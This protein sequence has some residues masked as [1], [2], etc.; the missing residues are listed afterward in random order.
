MST[1]LEAV[2]AALVAGKELPFPS[3]L[4]RGVHKH[5]AFSKD[6]TGYI[7][8][9]PWE[10][11]AKTSGKFGGI[12]PDIIIKEYPALAEQKYY[13]GG[14]LAG[15]PLEY[16]AIGSP[17]GMSWDE[18]G[19][20]AKQQYNKIFKDSV[21]H[22]IKR[23]GNEY[24]PKDIDDVLKHAREVASQETIHDLINA[25]YETDAFNRAGKWVN[26]TDVP[27]GFFKKHPPLR[28][29]DEVR[30]LDNKWISKVLGYM[31]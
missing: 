11:I 20:A 23:I 31:E 22:N 16:T 7:H 1:F 30:A 4:Y 15:D 13:R 26:R 6:P 3:K 5:F 12:N 14:S 28:T 2:K 17:A 10:H 18:L 24:G 27:K 25:S 9:T 29:N 19:T 8:T 21:K